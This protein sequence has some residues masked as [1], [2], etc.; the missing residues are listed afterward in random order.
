MIENHHSISYVHRN[1][2]GWMHL[3]QQLEQLQPT[4]IYVLVDENTQQHCLPYFL[5]RS[6]LYGNC[7]AL[8]MKAG[9]ANKTID[10]CVSLWKELSKRNADRKSLLINLGGGVVTDLGGFVACT[11]KRGIPFINIPTTLLAMVDASIGG[12]NGVD[13]GTVKNQIGTIQSPESVLI[14]THFL[15]TLPIAEIRSGQAEMLKHGLITSED[16]WERSL[17]FGLDQPEEAAA[18]IWESIAI[19]HAIVTQDPTEQNLRKTLNYGHTIGHAIESHFLENHDKTTLLHGEAVAIGMALATYLSKVLFN[20]PGEQLQRITAQLIEIFGKVEFLPRDIDAIIDLLK[21]DKKN[22]DG[23]VLFVLL[24]NF[25]SPKFN[26]EVPNELIH[27]AFTF[28]E[29]FNKI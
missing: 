1:E 4:T 3:R 16:Y 9:E 17:A 20:F 29:N 28:Y 19:K 21:F 25:G 18:L 15:K 24:E 23:K 12:K 8:I 26:C 13:L 14:D 7:T 5:E 6:G 22:L 11:F 10:T 27:N 2:W